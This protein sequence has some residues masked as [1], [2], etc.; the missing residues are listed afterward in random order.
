MRPKT[1]GVLG[2]AG[3]L[4]GAFLLERILRLAQTFY[5]CSR[6]GDFPK[7]ILINFPFSDMLSASKEREKVQRELYLCLDELQKNGAEIIAIACNTLHAFLSDKP[8]NLIRLPEIAVDES[9][10]LLGSSTSAEARLF[11]CRVPDRETQC[12]LDEIIVQILKGQEKQA[13]VRLSSLIQRTKESTIVLGCTEFSLIRERLKCP[14][15][16]LIDPLEIAALNI[17]NR[18][19][20]C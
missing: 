9:A 16:T 15:K 1:I 14:G 4:A 17:I 13:A 5:G 18:S 12:E 3:P 11:P 10:L 7:I 19:Y 20:Q 6:D 8:E 2:G